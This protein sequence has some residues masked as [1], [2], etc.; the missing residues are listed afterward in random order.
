M[1]VI[2]LTGSIGMGK[3]TAG[4][5][6][7]SLGVPVHEADMAVHCLLTPGSKAWGAFTAAFPY[8]SYPSVYR[9]KWSWKVWR[10]GGAPWLRSVNRA[11]LGRIVFQDDAAREK[12]E[13]ALH[14]FVQQEQDAFI[15]RQHALGKKIVALDI[16]LLFETGAENR[17]DYTITVDAPDFIQHAR[18]LARPG[19]DREKLSA[20]LGRQI[21]NGEKCACSDFVVHSGQGRAVMMKELKAILLEL[22][23]HQGAVKA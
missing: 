19:M 1:I 3:S 21:P 12:L 2:G 7:E 11:E 23:K 18:V 10:R 4:G 20:I 15:R 13:N 22:Q 5:L 17:V 14:P 9:K 6:L 16:P 8:F